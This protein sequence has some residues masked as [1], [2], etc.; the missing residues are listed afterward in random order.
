MRGGKPR[1]NIITRRLT[2]WPPNYWMS[3]IHRAALRSSMARVARRRLGKQGDAEVKMP[4]GRTVIVEFKRGN[5]SVDQVMR[6]ALTYVP[7]ASAAIVGAAG[8]FGWYVRS[9]APWSRR[10]E[11]D[12]I[13]GDWRVVGDD[14]WRA[15]RAASLEGE[16]NQP[17]LFDPTD[18]AARS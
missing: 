14:I 16:D 17:H 18:Y 1:R 12:A 8:V 5:V 10:A 15:A 4:D 7:G 6:Q 13:Y 3:S 9:D 11:G 2:R